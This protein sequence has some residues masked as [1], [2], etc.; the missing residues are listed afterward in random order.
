M[1]LVATFD[2]I[3]FNLD[4]KLKKIFDKQVTI[5]PSQRQQKKT[6]NS[7][8]DKL[9]DAN[10]SCKTKTASIAMHVSEEWL[11]LF[12]KQLDNLMDPENW[13]EEDTPITEK[14]FNTL[15]RMLL[16]IAPKNRPGLGATDTGNIIATWT[17]DKD[18]L[19]IECLP[20]DKVRWV[21]SSYITG[22]RESAAGVTS[23]RRLLIVLGPYDHKHWF[24]DDY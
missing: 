21:L 15:L 18:R 1:M 9:H 14:S 12:F 4:E 11:T 6:V 24:N 22:N 5:S 17:N 10:V 3:P 8:E 2:D 13:E 7:I 16:F 20:D 19:T 23:L